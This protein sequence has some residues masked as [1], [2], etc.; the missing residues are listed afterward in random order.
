MKELQAKGKG[1]GHGIIA[2]KSWD[3]VIVDGHKSKHL[4]P[5]N[6]PLLN[7]MPNG[8]VVLRELVVLL[9]WKPKPI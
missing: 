3:H 5:P 9:W 2:F 1:L 4:N 8:C 7:F 6:G